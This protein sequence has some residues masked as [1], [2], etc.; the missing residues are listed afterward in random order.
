LDLRFL[1]SEP[2]QG[3]VAVFVEESI[4]Q[5]IPAAGIAASGQKGARG[6][7]LWEKDVAEMD[8]LAVSKACDLELIDEIAAR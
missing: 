3:V 7:A 2:T 1:R 8:Q 4:I 5:V 6:K